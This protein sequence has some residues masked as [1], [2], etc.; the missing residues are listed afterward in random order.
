MFTAFDVVYVHVLRTPS[1]VMADDLNDE[2]ALRIPSAP[3]GDA[4]SNMY[5]VRLQ[6]YASQLGC[7]HN[8]GTDVSHGFTDMVSFNVE[9]QITINDTHIYMWD[10]LITIVDYLRVC[11][12]Y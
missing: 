6:R 8:I 7:Q 2:F 5:T 1:V 9:M 4:H 10:K 3:T 11:R 12:P